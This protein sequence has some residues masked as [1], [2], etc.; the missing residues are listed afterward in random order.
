MPAPPA[1]WYHASTLP[2]R[3]APSSRRS[4]LKQKL[5]GVDAQ[6]FGLDDLETGSAVDIDAIHGRL[7]QRKALVRKP[8]S[9]GHLFGQELISEGRPPHIFMTLQDTERR[10]IVIMHWR[11]MSA[12]A[13]HILK[14]CHFPNLLSIDC[15]KRRAVRRP[16][17]RHGH[18]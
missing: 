13:F 16:H 9:A 1:F 8:E 6:L 18:I 17:I 11:K 5:A 2:I 4:A 14:I 12:D 15:L 3:R 7:V 10:E